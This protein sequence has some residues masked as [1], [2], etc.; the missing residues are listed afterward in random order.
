MENATLEEGWESQAFDQVCALG[1]ISAWLMYPTLVQ[2]LLGLVRCRHLDSGGH[3]YL[4][5]DMSIKCNDAT[6]GAWLFLLF[7]F[8]IIYILGIPLVLL[9][10]LSSEGE[11]FN[12]VGMRYRVGFL[13]KG[14]DVDRAWWWEL[15]VF[16]R[17]MVLAGIV[18]LFSD[19]PLYGAYLSVWLLE[20]CFVIHLLADPYDNDRQNRLEVYGLIAAI[21][22]INCGILYIDGAEG[23]SANLLTVCVFAIHLGMW[24][25]LVKSLLEEYAAEGRTAMIARAQHD[26]QLEENVADELE[27]ARLDTSINAEKME[28]LAA[29]RSMAGARMPFADNDL[30]EHIQTGSVP[31][32][33]GDH[34][35]LSE[36]L[37]EMRAAWKERHDADINGQSKFLADEAH[38]GQKFL[39]AAEKWR[40]RQQHNE[41]DNGTEHADIQQNNE[42]GSTQTG[43]QRPWRERMKDRTTSAT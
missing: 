7:L 18:V 20:A 15:I 9:S 1:I 2:Y 39:S 42:I 16:V 10:I 27:Q 24:A 26:I 36:K 33:R 29:L 14:Q 43:D 41:N 12:T 17:K 40:R 13:Y 8:G 31:D 37:K 4:M 11:N 30:L 5:A 19:S 32:V 22:T 35:S 3:V 23:H 38:R 21:V 28:K 25:L 6:H 34:T